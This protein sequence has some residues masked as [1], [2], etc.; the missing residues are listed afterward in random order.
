MGSLHCATLGSHCGP[1]SGVS[2]RQHATDGGKGSS[3]GL[4]S[5]SSG[6]HSSG[7]NMRLST[8]TWDAGRA[9][10]PFLSGLAAALGSGV[11]GSALELCSGSRGQVPWGLCCA[12]K[13]APPAP[14]KSQ[15][16]SL[17]PGGHSP[18]GVHPGSQD[19]IHLGPQ[20]MIHPGSPR[21]PRTACREAVW[22]QFWVAVGWSQ[23]PDRN[24]HNGQ[25]QGRQDADH[26][27]GSYVSLGSCMLVRA[28]KT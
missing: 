6:R 4:N 19:M 18:Q 2:A 26:R 8:I 24:P 3:Q 20:D 11:V 1:S 15:G 21:T 17:G 28:F 25:P 22:R 14:S 10:S 9:S 16:C 7:P 27:G 13:R 23:T 5:C 12:H